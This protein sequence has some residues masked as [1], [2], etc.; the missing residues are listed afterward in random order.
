MRKSIVIFALIIL[1]LPSVNHAADSLDVTPFEMVAPE[2]EQRGPFKPQAWF[3]N[4]P[5]QRFLPLHT[6]E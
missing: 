5:A 2:E 4:E 3:A 6:V 1:A